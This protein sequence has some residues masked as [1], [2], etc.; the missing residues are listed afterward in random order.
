[1]GVEV[2]HRERGRCRSR[3]V[4][5]CGGGGFRNDTL[6]LSTPGGSS[7]ILP[8]CRQDISI[9]RAFASPKGDREASFYPSYK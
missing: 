8:M 1:M 5:V 2:F 7:C 9:S 6:K 3:D 4:C